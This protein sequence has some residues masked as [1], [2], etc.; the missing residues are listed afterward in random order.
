ME[1]KKQFCQW[2]RV[3]YN[4]KFVERL[5]AKNISEKNKKIKELKENENENK[6]IMIC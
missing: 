2:V 1:G 4:D 5:K 6:K 3:S